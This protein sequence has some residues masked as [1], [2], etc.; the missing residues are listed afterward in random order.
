MLK[1]C[2]LITCFSH[3]RPELTCAELA[4]AAHLS[5]ATTRRMLAALKSGGWVERSSGDRY[6]LGLKMF[7]IGSIPVSSLDLRLQAKPILVELTA[8]WCETTY[9]MVPSGRRLALCLDRVE[10]ASPEKTVMFPL[11][12]TLPLHS[13]AAPLCLLASHPEYQADIFRR[14]LRPLAGRTIVEPNLL[15]ERLDKVRRSGY[16]V[17]MED[18]VPGVCAV[19]APVFDK[20]GAVIAA[21]S[22]GGPCTRLLPHMDSLKQ[23][24]MDGAKRISLA[25]GYCASTGQAGPDW[26]LVRDLIAQEIAETKDF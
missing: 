20:T 17:S 1:T 14:R 25:L 23:A 2:R 12:A 13:G 6:R 15:K 10:G 22:M 24:V 21:I 4:R 7:Q 26:Q 11:G 16:A 5:V 19:G 3:D 18:V 9:L 8:R